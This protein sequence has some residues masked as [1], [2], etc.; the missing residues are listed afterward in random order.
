[1]LLLTKNPPLS[2]SSVSGPPQLSSCT[3]RGPPHTPSLC[4]LLHPRGGCSDLPLRLHLT[5]PPLSLSLFLSRLAFPSLCVSVMLRGESLPIGQ[6]LSKLFTRLRRQHSRNPILLPILV[7]GSV[8]AIFLFLYLVSSGPT[9][10]PHPSS[11]LSHPNA[12]STPTPDS[13]DPPSLDSPHAAGIRANPG[14]SPATPYTPPSSSLPLPSRALAELR[15]QLDACVLLMDFE[16][17]IGLRKMMKMV[18]EDREKGLH[19]EGE[20]SEY[21]EL[22]RQR[23]ERGELEGEGKAAAEGGG[24]RRRGRGLARG[25]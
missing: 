14:D 9:A 6:R 7:V 4:L 10:T 5:V 20:L 23:V 17:A 13:T 2:R 22:L 16:G 21:I 25:M 12:A 1:M 15:R 18:G 3:P 11:P 8:L 24:Q 19:R